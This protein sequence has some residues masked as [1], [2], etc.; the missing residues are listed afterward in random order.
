MVPIYPP[1]GPQDM[2]RFRQLKRDERAYLRFALEFY[3]FILDKRPQQAE[4]LELAANHFTTLGYYT[5]GL[6]VDQRLA[7]IRPKDP[8]VMYNLG[9]SFSLIGR[10]DDAIETLHKAVLN[11]YEDYKHMAEDED[12]AALRHDPRFHELILSMKVMLADEE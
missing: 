11:G 3:S 6:L 7:Q 5:D 12:L 10:P 1:H 9:C 4:A 8:N 2:E